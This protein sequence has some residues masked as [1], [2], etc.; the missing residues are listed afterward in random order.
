MPTQIDTCKTYMYLFT[1]SVMYVHGSRRLS[2]FCIQIKLNVTCN[3]LSQYYINKFTGA[4]Y[5]CTPFKKKKVSARFK[6][7]THLHA[8]LN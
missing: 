1:S 4:K 2:M 3:N 5:C 6:Q 7:Y 8:F